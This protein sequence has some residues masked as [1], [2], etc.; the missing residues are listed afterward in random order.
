M[1]FMSG[2]KEE[3]FPSD[4]ILVP[5]GGGGLISGVWPIYIKDVAPSMA[6]IGVRG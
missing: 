2:L 3:L 5:V 4:S 6:V 1:K